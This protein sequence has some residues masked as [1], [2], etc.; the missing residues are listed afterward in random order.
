M[1]V[2]AIFHVYSHSALARLAFPAKELLP[3]SILETHL[4]E[5]KVVL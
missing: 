1:E 4:D 2:N 3:C 5:R